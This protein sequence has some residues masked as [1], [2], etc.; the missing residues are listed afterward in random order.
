MHAWERK[1]ILPPLAVIFLALVT[2]SGHSRAELVTALP[3]FESPQSPD[4]Q[5]LLFD[6]PLP[7]ESV[8]QKQ[9]LGGNLSGRVTDP[10]GAGVAN[11]TVIVKEVGTGVT[12]QSGRADS[13]GVYQFEVPRDTVVNV[14]AFTEQGGRGPN[15]NSAF[16]GTTLSPCKSPDTA[17]NVSLK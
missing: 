17:C 4:M 3:I 11:A 12:L 16:S 15:G 1:P 5:P 2:F 14:A 10:T 7:N 9:D 6:D 8:T 13:E